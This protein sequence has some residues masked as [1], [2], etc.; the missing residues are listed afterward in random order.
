MK[1]IIKYII[2]QLFFFF[3]NNKKHNNLKQVFILN[4]ISEFKE[5]PNIN[6]YLIFLK[7]RKPVFTDNYK[8]NIVYYDSKEIPSSNAELLIFGKGIFSANLLPKI[9]VDY[10]FIPLRDAFFKGAVFSKYFFKY[11]YF[12]TGVRKYNNKIGVIIQRK[13]KL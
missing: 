10:L 9:K 8:N 11:G 2:I 12:F 6:N 13:N 5:S 7:K 1:K 3:K 4:E